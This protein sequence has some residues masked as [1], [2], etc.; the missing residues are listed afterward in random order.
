M[1]S[2][3][4][5][6]G[7]A[8]VA[9]IVF[10]YLLL[11]RWADRFE[12]E[13]PWLLVASFLWGAIVASGAAI[14][15]IAF[16]EHGVSAAMEQGVASPV[17]AAASDVVVAPVLEEGFKALGLIVLVLVCRWLGEFDGPL[18]GLVYGG[19]IGLG[20]TLTEDVMY[21]SSAYV[22]T[23]FDGVSTVTFLRTVLGG[24]GH[25]TFTALTG[26]GLGLAVEAR[27]RAVR[28]AAPLV[29]WVGAVALHVIHNVLAGIEPPRLFMKIVVF[30]GVDLLFFVGLA[31][32]VRRERLIIQRELRAEPPGLVDE[33]EIAAV[34]TYVALDMSLLRILLRDGLRAYQELCRRQRLLVKIALLKHRRRIDP[35]PRLSSAEEEARRA[36]EELNRRDVRLP[37]PA[38]A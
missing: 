6:I 8:C 37:A 29:L 4:I 15:G 21:V 28:I 10:A 36:I 3:G 38:S 22:R 20:F 35:S 33:R 17:V 9:P 11:V 1:S 16:V 18:D 25:C 19:V 5:L 2:V 30:W 26:L 14:A 24:L 23:G 12:P 13:P 32:C 7:L 27:S 34:S 31:L